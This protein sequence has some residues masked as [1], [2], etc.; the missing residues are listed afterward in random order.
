MTFELT[1]FDEPGLDADYLA[2]MLDHSTADAQS[3]AGRL[4]NYFRNPLVPATA[5]TVGALNESSRPY[6]Q[7]QEAGLPSRITGVANS[8]AGNTDLHRKEVVIE[9]DIAWRVQTMV[10]FLF[11]RTPAIRSLAGDKRTAALIE[12]IISAILQANG[13][14]AF[15]QEAALIGSIYGFVDIALRTPAD[16]LAPMPVMSTPQGTPA[17]DGNAPSPSNAASSLGGQP[18]TPDI[19]DAAA[20]A[21]V[22]FAGQLRLEAIEAGRVMP[23]LD[24]Y[25]YRRVRMWVQRFE[26]NPPQMEDRRNGWQRL[27]GRGKSSAPASTE[28]IE[29]IGRNWWQRYEDRQL[30][31]EGPNPL[32]CL[33]IVHI[34]NV[35]LAG[36]YAGL[37]DVEPLIPLQDEL[38]TRLSDR[39]QRVT[40]QSFKMYLGKGIDDFLDRPVGP[41]QMWATHNMEASI[42]EFGSDD[43]SPSEDAHI[44]QVRAALDKVS[45]VSPLAA[46]LVRDNVG[47]LTSG[48]AL[49][50]VLGGLLARTA[51]KRLTYGAGLQRIVELSLEWLDR[52]GVLHTT[53]DD[54]RIEIHW[55]NM[56]PA[57]EGEQLRNAQIKAQLGVPAERIMAELGY[58]REEN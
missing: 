1:N 23:I 26:V 34:Q 50:V 18:G 14:V 40:Y 55:P 8:F 58:G 24:E 4:W 46:G 7:A 43:G 32:G 57:D 37:S 17:A 22:A 45:G 11:S 49:K 41:G 13:G 25:D 35:A 47:Y 20:A 28:V 51:R 21:I 9:N 16:G 48:T 29:L 19:S 42:E 38:N 33:P 54:R 15:L 5:I 10:D 44:E 36:S 53:A 12:R 39:A 56:T 3:H 27:L 2:H 52:C 6:F 30:T 31:A